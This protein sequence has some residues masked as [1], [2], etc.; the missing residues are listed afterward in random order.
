[1]QTT[2][3]ALCRLAGFALP[4][5][6]SF[7]VNMIANFV[8]MMM[9]GKLGYLELA[10]GAL[11]V[12]TY[13]T[14]LTIGTSLFYSIGILISHSCGQEKAPEEIGQI[15]KNGLWLTIFIGLPGG[16]MLWNI[17]HVLHFFKQDPQLIALTERYF[18]HAAFAM[19]STLVLTLLNQ[20]YMGINRP[21]VSMLIA[22]ISLPLNILLSYGLVLGHFGL[23]RLGLG[24][25]TFSAS[26]V[27]AAICCLVLAYIQF[28]SAFTKYQIFSKGLW[29]NKELCKGILKL[30]VPI[31]AQSGVELAAMT[32][33][34]YLMGNFG[35]LAL[36]ASQ[37][38]SQYAMLVIM[39]ILGM[40]QALAVLVSEAY[41][42]HDINLIR[43]NVRAAFILLS[44][45]FTI[46]LTLFFF[47]A[48][49]LIDF[50][51][52]AR[53]PVNQNLV[54]LATKL[55]VVAG[56]FLLCDGARNL[57]AGALRGI[58]DTKAPMRVGTLCLLF[59]S[60]PLSYLVGFIFKGGPVGLRA[61]FVS[62]FLLAAVFLWKRLRCKITI[63]AKY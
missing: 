29:P 57:L 41:G 25:V 58:H 22:L 60:L 26:I 63:L 4:I 42:R 33:T 27:Q 56:V 7:L 8:A 19:Y 49:A 61:G 11:G 40:S 47:F 48:H 3:S 34:T 9:V 45:L 59:V 12:S 39:I 35:I 5:C 37:I 43:L 62:G 23:P 15:F 28:S 44:L 6:A 52:E 20:F 32:G 17:G 38:I 51:I 55:F 13:I 16:L 46:I 18:H 14:I 30:G 10:A 24:G 53:H 2:W 1:M 31:G 36:A 54:D 50:Y 21:R